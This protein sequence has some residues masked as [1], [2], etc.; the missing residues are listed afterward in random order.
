MKRILHV[1]SGLRTGGAERALT[2]LLGHQSLS[3]FENHV[4]S[5]TGE[6]TEG[7]RVRDAGAI[8][9]KVESGSPLGWIVEAAKVCRTVRP[10]VVHGWMYHGNIAATAAS[11][12]SSDRPPVLWAIRQSLSDISNEKRLTR[13]VIKAGALAS[14]WPAAIVYNS[15]LSQAQHEGLGYSSDKSVVIPNGFD[16]VSTGFKAED[17]LDFWQQFG[18]D[19]RLPI[20]LH[21]GRF[22]PVKGHSLLLQAAMNILA[23]SQA[24]QFVL[25]GLNVTPD[26][27]EREGLS[28]QS[29]GGRITL[30][31]LR[32]NV[33]EFMAHSDIFVLSSLAEAFPNV[34][35]EAMAA[36]LP[37]VATD[38]GDA[39]HIIGR[40]GT[41]VPPGDEPALRGAIERYLDNPDLRKSHGAGAK[42]RIAQDYSIDAVAKTYVELYE[43]IQVR[44]VKDQCAE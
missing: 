20:V 10:D 22:H 35:G 44:R 11:F 30:L 38:V 31:G 12:A 16:T 8:V 29:G 24:V 33:D 19:G 2:R 42:A 3:Q 28:L 1:I 36:G 40:S 9:H 43:R 41:I 15:R 25:I 26:F 7:G 17:R 13:A 23:R 5:L 32:Q 14:R 18:V 21:V 39:R 34:V 4:L 37:C 27:F 6:G